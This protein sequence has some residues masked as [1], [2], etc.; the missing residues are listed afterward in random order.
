MGDEI[1]ASDGEQKDMLRGDFLDTHHENT[2]KFLMSMDWVMNELV[3]HCQPNFIMVSRE[4]IYHNVPAI[5]QMLERDYTNPGHPLYMGKLLRRDV[6]IRDKADLMYV[7]KEDYNKDIFPNMIQSPTYLFSFTAFRMMHHVRES[8]TP[9]APADSYIG[10]LA[11]KAGIKPFNNP[12][13]IMMHLG[14]KVAPCQYINQFFVYNVGI[15][16]IKKVYNMHM[17]QINECDL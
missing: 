6:P 10:L 9:I 15:S 17:E 4:R 8:V 13:F 5:L 7:S 2:R 16:D 3:P 12:Q 14:S 11:E 1:R